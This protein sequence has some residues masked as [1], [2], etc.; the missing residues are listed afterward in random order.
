MASSSEGGGDGS[1]NGSLFDGMVLFTPSSFTDPSLPQPAASPPPDVAAASQPQP[2]SQPFDEDLFSDLTIQIPPSPT[3]TLRDP[4]PPT[5]PPLPSSPR[6]PP[7]L[8]PRQLSRKKKRA[9]RIGYARE[10]AGGAAA[11]SDDSHHLSDPLCNKSPPPSCGATAIA[12]ANESMADEP[13]TSPHDASVD[14]AAHHDTAM[15]AVED[16]L[17]PAPPKSLEQPGEEADEGSSNEAVVKE[18]KGDQRPTEGGGIE[19]ETCSSGGS[20][21]GE[22]VFGSAEERLQLVRTQIS[23]KLESVRQRAASA[24]AERKELERSRRRAV[25]SVNAAST[26]HRDLEK[27]L[28]LACEA[29]DFERAERVSE[30]LMT[31]EEEKAKLL[32]SLREAEADCELAELK[33]QEVLEL[34]IAVEEEC[35][36]LLEQFAKDAADCAESVLKNAEE[37]SCKEIEEW[38]SSVE[39]LEVKKLE[40]DIE[41]QLISEAHSGLENAIEDLVK[42]DREEKEMLAR[43]G[44][45]LEKE[46]DELLELVRLKEA[47]IAENKSQIQ[48]VDN[49]I[50]NVVSKFHE[51]QSIIDMK[52]KTLQEAFL[53]VESEDGALL[54]RKEEIDEVISSAEKKRRKLIELS[55]IASN[56]A[57]TCQDLLQLKK[58]LASFILKSREDRVRYSKTEEK[59]SED[60]QILRQEI[61]AARTALQELSSTRAS[62]QQEVTLYKQRIGFIEKRGPELEA[63]KKVAAAAR[64]FRE[65]GRV[66]AEAKSLHIEKEDLRHKKEKAVL[67][68]EK[69]EEE[70]GSNVER[71]QKNEELVLLKEK[72]A[73]L[74]GCNRLQLVAAAARAERSVALKMGDVEEGSLLL[75]EA[76][77]VESKVMELQKVY[78]LDIEMDEKNLVS[79]VFITNLDGDHLSESCEVASFNIDA[80]VGSES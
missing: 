2:E 7:A 53:K 33:M 77:A 69:L 51:T 32:L 40:M 25:E 36:D 47:E 43:K 46:L 64:N 62:I 55:A 22:G 35:I 20:A 12:V 42:N 30:N 39:L 80:V 8:L 15:P 16:D 67:H 63:E 76:E 24:Y 68:L 5:L 73:A 70:I 79:L 71:I 34:Q 1:L 44:V 60:I 61:S 41:L 38:Q 52:H 3:A 18:G 65:A 58:Q 37:T 19:E 66:A 56:E 6:Q 57:K 28:E 72:E 21:T 27:D 31:V 45:I 11:S 29:E 14:S 49:R 17:I 54:I 10:T 48:D 75:K 59:I 9:V 4:P 78:N 26:K 50:S 13:L 74:A 23:K